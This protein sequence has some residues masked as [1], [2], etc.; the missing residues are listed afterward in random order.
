[1]EGPT[2]DEYYG[3]SGGTLKAAD[4]GDGLEVV[5]KGFRT[6]KF[7][8]NEKPTL[9]LQL[10]EQEKEFRVNWTNAQRIAEMYGDAIK[11]WV[12]KTLELLP[13]K[14][15][16]RQGKAFDTITV[17]VRKTLRNAP[18]KTT[19]HDDRNPPPPLDDEVP[20]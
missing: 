12:G 16:D 10:E 3:T 1:M 11:G 7:D 15:R 2:I 6:H 8:N 20:F 13:D 4:I 5:V 18:N 9:F 17:R 14:G 19:R